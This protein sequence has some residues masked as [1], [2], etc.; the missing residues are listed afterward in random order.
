MSGVETALPIEKLDFKKITPVLVIILVD[1]LGLSIIVPLMPLYAARFGANAFVI[2]L[3]G[4]TYPFMQFIGAPVLGRFS[5]RIGRRPILLVSQIGT[6][7]GFILLGFANALP[8]LFISRIIDGLSGANISTAQAVVTDLTSDETRTQGLGLIGA[9][10]G[11]GF[12]LGPIIAF[13]VLI[14]SGNNYQ[15]VAFTAAFFSLVSLLLTLFWLP[16]TRNPQKGTSRGRSPFSFQAM[17]QAL[18]RPTIGILLLLMFTQQL[19]FGGYEQMFSLFA[20]NRLGM[21]ARDTSGLFVL[22]GLFI[23]AIQGGFIGRWSKTYGDRWLVMLGLSAL[24]IGLILTACTPQIPVPWYNQ[25]RITAEMQGRNST[26]IINVT[27]P[28]ETNK[29]WPGII[30]VLVASFPAALGGGVLHPAINSL[31]TKSAGKDEVGGILGVSAGFYSAANAITPLFFGSLFQW[32]G[33][34]VPF[35]IGGLL[36][37]VLSVIAMRTVKAPTAAAR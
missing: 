4:S 35:L 22:A 36:L 19:A 16:E 18:N 25:V 14:A 3:L 26:Q 27:L 21:G 23:V 20:L 8:L 34:P 11:M 28:P 10:F 12:I 30:W 13:S 24:A 2:G 29:G 15:A 32:F 37:A 5:D 9:A 31:I 7:L 17:F 33:P 1:L 6:F